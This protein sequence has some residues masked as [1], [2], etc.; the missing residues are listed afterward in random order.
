MAKVTRDNLRKK[1]LDKPALD[2][3]I[4][5]RKWIGIGGVYTFPNGTKIPEGTVSDYQAIYDSGRVAYF[6][7]VESE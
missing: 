1:Y 2:Q 7:S 6:N 4:H 3:V 5:T